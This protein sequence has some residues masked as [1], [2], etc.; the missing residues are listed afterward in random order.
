M[1]LEEL[2]QIWKEQSKKLSESL[3]LNEKMLKNVFSRKANGE[4][5]KLIGWNYFS[6]IEFIIFLVFVLIATYKFM[7]DWR[8]LLP[9]IFLILFFVLCIVDAVKSIRELNGIN[10][11]SQ[12]I[13]DFKQCILKYKKRSNKSMRLLLFIIPPLIPS[14]ILL[15]VRFIR[16][17]NLLD[18][19]NFFIT[20]T[21][22]T[23]LLSYPVA[24]LSNQLIL[25]R[26]FRSIEN[27]LAEL[28]KFKEE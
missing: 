9:G 4:I 23:I 25:S 27:N 11:F 19:P 15:G 18:Y 26:K 8:L 1:E 13:I 24:F 10:L 12:S 6:S 3:A 22:V 17:I 16:N 5:E 20:L 2:K 28:E 7:D 21:I 14:F